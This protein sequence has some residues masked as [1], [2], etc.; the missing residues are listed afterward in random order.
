MPTDLINGPAATMPHNDVTL[1]G[2]T[3]SVCA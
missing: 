1:R 3:K 2:F